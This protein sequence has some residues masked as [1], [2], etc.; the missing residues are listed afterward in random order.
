MYSGLCPEGMLYL[1]IFRAFL[2]IMLF[3]IEDRPVSDRAPANLD[4]G[5]ST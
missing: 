2:I 4:L 1:L 3:A 5:T